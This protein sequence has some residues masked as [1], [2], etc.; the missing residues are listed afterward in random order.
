[1]LLPQN[2]TGSERAA[3]FDAYKLQVSGEKQQER[4]IAAREGRDTIRK[5]IEE[6]LAEAL[7]SIDLTIT[8]MEPKDVIKLGL[9]FMGDSRAE[10]EKPL[11][12]LRDQA[13]A[14]KGQL[15]IAE[16]VRISRTAGPAITA[17]DASEHSS[18]NSFE[19]DTNIIDADY[20]DID[21]SS[22]TGT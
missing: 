16:L 10:F 15:T 5:S 19:S 12:K 7:Q 6:K 22:K 2:T 18:D 3:L 13:I 17:L 20:Q 21:T 4:L 11:E 9:A 8:P 1:M 14:A